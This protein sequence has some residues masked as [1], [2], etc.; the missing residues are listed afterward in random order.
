MN[1]KEKKILLTIIPYTIII[2]YCAYALMP[3]LWIVST[4]LKVPTEVWSW[5]TKWIP[6]KLMWGNYAEVFKG[7]PFERYI[8]NS[9]VVSLTVSAICIALGSLTGYV[10]S[11]Y[12]FKLDKFLFVAVLATRIFPPISFITPWYIIG[13]KMGIIDTY[14]ILIAMQIYMNLPFA[15]WIMRGFFDEMPRSIDEA[16]LIDGCTKTMVLRYIIL[17]LS[18]P[19]VAATAIIVFINSWNDYLFASVVTF[20]VASKT[21]PVGVVEF[22]GDAMIMWNLLSAA[23]I[24][25]CIPALIFILFFQR[26]IVQGLTAGSI[27]G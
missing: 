27:K 25:T 8:I 5:P 22:V 6:N 13:E 11:R 15:V 18:T 21:L 12:H 19:G 1:L 10:F 26:F 20:S 24:I 16:G 2:L 17:P 23:S 7:R 9:L 4:S 3:L 14:W